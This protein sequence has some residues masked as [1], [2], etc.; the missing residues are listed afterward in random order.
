M[1]TAVD[2]ARMVG[3]ARARRA[4]K[5][6]A[7]VGVVAGSMPAASRNSFHCVIVR[8][9]VGARVARAVAL[10]DSR[11]AAWKGAVRREEGDWRW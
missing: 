4:A 8:G 1:K 11:M 10:P 5:T 9:W 7:G 2:A 6:D 3:R